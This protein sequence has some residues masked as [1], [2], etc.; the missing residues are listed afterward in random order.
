MSTNDYGTNIPQH[1]IDALRG[2]CCRTFERSLPPKRDS[3]NTQNGSKHKP[4]K[5]KSPNKY[6]KGRNLGFRPSLVSLQN[7][8]D[9]N[10]K[11]EHIFYLNKMVRISLVWWKLTGSNR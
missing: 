3:K 11:S 5:K 6:N 9:R 8:I 1:E 7:H 10:E 4:L 2:C